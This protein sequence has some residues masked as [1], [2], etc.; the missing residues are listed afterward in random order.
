MSPIAPQPAGARVARVITRLNIGGPSIQAVRLTTALE[1]HGFAGTL[2][3]GR[4]GA[5]EGDMSYLIPSGADTRYLP[6]LCRPLSPLDDLRALVRLYREFR[7]LQPAIVHTHMAKAGMLGRLAAAAYNLSRGSAPRA[8]VVHTYHGHVLDGYFSRA[9]TAVFI[10]IERALATL[11][12]RIIAISPAIRQEL[13]HTYRIGRDAQYR[14][15]PLGF[16]LAPFAAIDAPARGEARR[17]LDLPAGA[18]VITTV[19]RLTAIKQHRLFLDTV[20]RVLAVH[21]GA[22]AVIAGD[23]EL[24][25]HLSAHA[26][27]IGIAD[28]VRMLGWRR[29]LPAIYAATDVFLLTSRNEGTPV[30]LIEAMASG[31]PGVST[32][33]GG[34]NDVIGGRDTGRTAPFGDADGLA[35]E[36]NELLSSPALRQEMGARARARVLA[37]YDLNRLVDD[38]AVLYRELVAER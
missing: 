14:V 20:K 16:D 21:P 18:L 8:R 1:P 24:K 32:D 7:A 36:I 22:M 12:D 3:H 2:F 38:I 11:S 33:V 4:L 15:V 30:A 25:D 6:S 34:V 37:H 23:G 28:R 26:S 9:A 31:V 27:S 29:D 5:G 19:G 13:L 10:G 35:R 17:A